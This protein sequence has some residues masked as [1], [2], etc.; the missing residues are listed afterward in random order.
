MRSQRT[1]QLLSSS[2]PRLVPPLT[3]TF[4]SLRI[5]ILLWFTFVF[6]IIFIGVLQWFYHFTTHEMLTQLKVDMKDTLQGAAQGV[7]VPELLS[8]YSEG[9]PNSEGFSDDIRFHNQLNW[10]DSIHQTEPQAWFYLFILNS[11][12][13]NRRVG[14]SRVSRSDSEIIY[15][16][17]L[18]AKY[19]KSKASHFLESDIPNLRAMKVMERRE[20][21]IY[22]KIYT[23][24]WGDW[25]SATAPL[26]D[27]N[28]SI[29]AMLGLDI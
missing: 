26:F 20:I 3:R 14:V 4:I 23:D 16:V 25:L 29:V 8:L 6:S 7:D 18:W 22:P 2:T 5:K 24:K 13:Q 1:A 12:H 21:V 28:G 9:M 27:S 19:D 17:D 10:L 11:A 15:L